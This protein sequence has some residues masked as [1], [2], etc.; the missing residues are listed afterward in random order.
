[1]KTVVITGMGRDASE[2]LLDK[3]WIVFGSIKNLVDA[4]D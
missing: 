3:G 1:M 2:Y 4:Q